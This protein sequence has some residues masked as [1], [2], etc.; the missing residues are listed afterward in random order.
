[1][2][3]FFHVN[4]PFCATGVGGG[5]GQKAVISHLRRIPT[6]SSKEGLQLMLMPIQGM[7]TEGEILS[8]VDL[9]I[10][11]A[12]FVP[13]IQLIFKIQISW[14]KLF[15]TRRSTVIPLQ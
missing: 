11:V 9:L 4:I 12:C 10:K 7:L 3:K 8:K 15:R 6:P 13:W 1:M 5:G 14:C 2:S